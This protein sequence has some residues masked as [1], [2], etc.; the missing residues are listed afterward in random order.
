MYRYMAGWRCE[1]AVGLLAPG[2]NT[3]RRHGAAIFEYRA[4]PRGSS[5]RG[6]LYINYRILRLAMPTLQNYNG[7]RDFHQQGL[8]A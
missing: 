7:V 8:D 1:L 2:F 3:W 4:G 6:A 5:E